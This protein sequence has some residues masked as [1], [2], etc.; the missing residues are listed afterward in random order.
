[1]SNIS[2]FFSPSRK[3]NREFIT[4]PAT[5]TWPVPPGITELEVHVWGGGGDGLTGGGGGGGYSRAKLQVGSGDQLSITVGGATETSTVT[6]PT[7]SP[8][9]PISSTG[10]GTGTFC[11]CAC[12]CQPLSCPNDCRGCAPG[13]AGGTGTIVLAAPQ[14]TIYCFTATG[15]AGGIGRMNSTT[16]TRTGGGG[17]SAGSPYGDGKTGG[18]ATDCN[19]TAS[20]ASVLADGCVKSIVPG[21]LTSCKFAATCSLRGAEGGSGLYVPD[22]FN[23]DQNFAGQGG[24][25]GYF[26]MGTDGSTCF[27]PGGPTTTCISYSVVNVDGERGGFL[28]GGGSGRGC[29]TACGA[30]NAGAGGIAG[31][32]GGSYGAGQITTSRG[33]GGGSGAV[34]IYY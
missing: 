23:M 3:T 16:T 1:M 32:G 33:A 2:Q 27:G 21:C 10:G 34:I 29:G 12:C 9:S 22:W 14:P 7:Q 30:T 13:G 5:R 28:A 11:P 24:D 4:G 17:G 31:G 19:H 18:S 20:G 26:Y 8:G 6:I 25:S 15:G